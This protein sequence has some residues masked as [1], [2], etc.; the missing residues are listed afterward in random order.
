MHDLRMGRT[1]AGVGCERVY[2]T[3]HVMILTGQ[4]RMGGERRRRSRR[5]AD[6]CCLLESMEVVDTK[7]LRQSQMSL[8]PNASYVVIMVERPT[9]ARL[10]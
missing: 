3:R 9:S 6:S 8:C 2:E 4:L 1:S 5:E 7:K 10:P